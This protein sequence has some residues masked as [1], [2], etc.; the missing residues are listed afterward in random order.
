LWRKSVPRSSRAE[1]RSQDEQGNCGRLQEAIPSERGGQFWALASL[2]GRAAK[3]SMTDALVE[4]SV[5]AHICHSI[6]AGLLLEFAALILVRPRRT[7]AL[8]CAV[9]IL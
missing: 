3:P 9:G 5:Y 1:D 7:V 2:R 6:Y 4:H 8:G